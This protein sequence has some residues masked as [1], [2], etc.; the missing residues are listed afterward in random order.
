MILQRSLN[1]FHSCWL[2]QHFTV[3]IIHVVTITLTYTVIIVR[4]GLVKRTDGQTPPKQQ[5]ICGYFAA[6]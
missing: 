6:A 4:F 5:S 3:V 2:I 1:Y